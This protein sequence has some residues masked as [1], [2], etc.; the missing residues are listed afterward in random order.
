MRLILAVSLASLPAA[1]LGALLPVLRRRNAEPQAQPQHV[2]RIEATR[3]AGPG[4]RSDIFPAALGIGRI[5]QI[6]REAAP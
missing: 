4:S 1:A 5:E 3:R 2:R 6:N